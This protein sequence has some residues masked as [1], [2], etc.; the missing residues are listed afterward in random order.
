MGR[1]KSRVWSMG[2][3]WWLGAGHDN[4]P[5]CDH[6]DKRLQNCEVLVWGRTVQP[7]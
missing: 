1:V 2:G 6:G 5:H 4:D 7:E 3:G